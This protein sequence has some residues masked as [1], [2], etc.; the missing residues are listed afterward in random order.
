M[1]NQL[2]EEQE[3][4]I[5]EIELQLTQN[6]SHPLIDIASMF[7]KEFKVQYAPLTDS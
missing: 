3:S 5:Q 6:K 1:G 4:V 7:V 2:T